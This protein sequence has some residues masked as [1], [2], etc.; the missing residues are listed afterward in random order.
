M[1][2]DEHRSELF[3]R[4]FRSPVE[5]LAALTFM[6]G[7]INTAA[8]AQSEALGGPAPADVPDQLEERTSRL[9]NGA[10]G[11]ALQLGAAS[12]SGG[13]SFPVGASVSIA[14]PPEK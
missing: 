14:G 9:S 8:A 1:N 4:D 6:T 2:I 11:I 10:A 5:G 12:N 3:G 13:V 7:G